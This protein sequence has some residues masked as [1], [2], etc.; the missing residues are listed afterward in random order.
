VE[1][2]QE[3]ALDLTR[4]IGAKWDELRCVLASVSL[5]LSTARKIAALTA[6]VVTDELPF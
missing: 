3:G 4:N 6:S 5:R 2:R 1:G